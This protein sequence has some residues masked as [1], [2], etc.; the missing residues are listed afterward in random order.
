MGIRCSKN[1]VARLM[2][3]YGIVAKTRRRCKVTTR[4]RKAAQYAPDRLQRRFVCERPHRVWTSDITYI[5][6]REGWL[7]LAVILDLCS[8]TIVGWATSAHIEAE[9][10]CAALRRAFERKRPCA[11]IVFLSDR[12]GRYVSDALRALIEESGK[13]QKTISTSSLST[14][15]LAIPFPDRSRIRWANYLI[16]E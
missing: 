2:R 1:R 4:A 9:L 16:S 14:T 15:V 8:R 3:R 7:Y 12:D 13:H 10:G 6:T 5:W 11:E